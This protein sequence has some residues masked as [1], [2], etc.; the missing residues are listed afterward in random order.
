MGTNTLNHAIFFLFSDVKRK[1]SIQEGNKNPAADKDSVLSINCVDSMEPLKYT[2]VQVSTFYF[3]LTF[4]GM[5][6][7]VN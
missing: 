2:D 1:S 5:I 3:A 7:Y 6:L 4:K